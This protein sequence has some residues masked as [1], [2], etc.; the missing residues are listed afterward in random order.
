MKR[1]VPVL[2]ALSLLACKDKEGS[3]EEET[4]SFPALAFI[5]S[6]VRDVDTSLYHIH[7]IVEDGG[8]ADTTSIS[9]EQF[10]KEAQPFLQ[11]P[12]INKSSLRDEYSE[13]K[14]FDETLQNVVYFYTAKDPEADL[15]R[16]QVFIDPNEGGG[17]VKKIIIDLF[18]N[19]NGFSAH[20]NLIWTSNSHFQISEN[21]PGPG[22]TERIRRTR[23]IWNDFPS[24]K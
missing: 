19:R 12:D 8:H 1:F 6:Q 9:R 4:G 14:Y 24:S 15:Q 10:R 21:A 17:L 5:Q 7:K 13:S 16:E 2:L 11:L 18:E 23:I 20:R 3:S 22:G